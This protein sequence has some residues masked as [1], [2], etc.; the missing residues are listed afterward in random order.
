MSELI[1][2]NES[3]KRVAKEIIDTLKS[4]KPYI[5]FKIAGARR[6]GRSSFFEEV[7]DCL[8]C[9]DIFP[10]NCFVGELA[11]ATPKGFAETL[12][13]AIKS[14]SDDY[15]L[16]KEKLQTPDGF[17]ELCSAL[18]TNEGKP[19]VFLI[20][21]GEAFEEMYS[22]SGL[23]GINDLKNVLRQIINFLETRNI[24][25]VLGIGLTS[26]FVQET[27]DFASDVFVHRFQSSITLKNTFLEGE[28]PRDAFQEIVKKLS[29]LD[30]PDQ[31]QGL[32]RGDTVTAG[33]LGE[34]LKES[35]TTEITSQVI[36]NN[37]RGK[38]KILK[39]NPPETIPAAQL[40]E[41]ILADKVIDVN[42]Y[43]DHLEPCD[44]GFRAKDKLYVDLGF[45]SPRHDPST[46]D[47]I[48]RKLEDHEDDTVVGELLTNI[49]QRMEELGLV[50]ISEPELLG[51]RIALMESQINDY[52]SNSSEFEKSLYQ[53]AF[54]MTLITL[55]CLSPN[56]E[57]EILLQR[58]TEY[59]DNNYFILILVREGEDWGRF[60]LGRYIS[61]NIKTAR[62]QTIS[63]EDIIRIISNPAEMPLE[64]FNNWIS[65]TISELFDKV[66]VLP[67]CNQY[68]KQLV[69]G[70]ISDG[71]FSIDEFA[72]RMGLKKIDANKCL[73]LLVHSRI[74]A[75]RKT[76]AIWE[77]ENDLVL[78]ILLE[79]NVDEDAICDQIKVNYAISQ[80]DINELSSLY[81]CI[82]GTNGLSD[83]TEEK[84]LDHAG[85]ILEHKLVIIG[86]YLEDGSG[87][88]GDF[89]DKYEICKNRELCEIE[90]ITPF[91]SDILK[92]LEDIENEKE[93]IA[94]RLKQ[95]RID[96]IDKKEHF[97]QM[98]EINADYLSE[99]EKINYLNIIESISDLG[100]NEF[101]QIER[102]V[103]NRKVA[104]DELRS[105]LEKISVR[106]KSLKSFLSE[107]EIKEVEDEI[108][109]IKRLINLYDTDEACS[110]IQ[111]V[112]A[113]LIEMERCKEERAILVGENITVIDDP[114]PLGG[115][116][117]Q[118]P[119][120]PPPLGGPSGQPPHITPPLSEPSEQPPHI[121][122][123]LSGPS[124]S[125]TIDETSISKKTF[126]L[127]DPEQCKALAKM[128][129]EKKKNIARIDVKVG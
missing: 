61:N 31:F 3:A 13:E 95:V 15:L 114:P 77:P 41:L 36:W 128:L 16:F 39:H 79:N 28:N 105:S 98:L 32:W 125:T 82:T 75:R 20:D 71:L 84:I 69:S 14:C 119:H 81:Q 91:F 10:V 7:S 115:P 60:P 44:G 109:V 26:Q 65:E 59:A 38:W 74:L 37:L 23:V 108:D 86:R 25:L 51:Q 102:V 56:P 120:I 43:P 92:L 47:R 117:G 52:I 121:P 33:Q 1:G 49:G 24:P 88:E 100:A 113:K 48:K 89:V 80:V 55:A 123:P 110:H 104:I 50:D 6:S 30:L 11:S 112:D 54:P 42:R 116:S 99:D 96:L 126:D 21:M 46:R 58:L 40:G 76:F 62:I 18:N 68:I 122:P 70:T 35:R 93:K 12:L 118:P 124:G 111:S 101:G 8:N 87:L 22:V 64:V 127:S 107:T 106:L 4:M 63:L 45:Y 90:D 34:N 29:G 17:F 97:K 94:K 53:S 27:K 83:L 67:V 19:P 78:K 9:N 66:P 57:D 73:S 103:K 2:Y 5:G 129:V 85:K 72:E